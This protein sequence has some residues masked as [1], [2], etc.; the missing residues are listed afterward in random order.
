MEKM[1]VPEHICPK[2]GAVGSLVRNMSKV[3][4]TSRHSG[5]ACDYVAE[6][7]RRVIKVPVEVER[8]RI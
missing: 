3:E 1:I 5:I 6:H 8:R 7:E 4:C 2:C